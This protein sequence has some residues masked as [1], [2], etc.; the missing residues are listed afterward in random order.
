MSRK[1]SSI[2]HQLHS[3]MI[4]CLLIYLRNQLYQ[5]LTPP[6]ARNSHIINDCLL[7]LSDTNVAVRNSATVKDLKHAVENKVNE[8]EQSKMGHRHIFCM[9]RNFCL[10]YHNEKLLNDAAVLQSCHTTISKTTTHN[11]FSAGNPRMNQIQAI[12]QGLRPHSSVVMGKNTFM[13]HSLE[14]HAPSAGKPAFVG[15]IYDIVRNVGMIFT[16]CDPEEVSE[17]VAEYKLQP[18]VCSSMD[19]GMCS[20][21]QRLLGFHL[22]LLTGVFVDGYC[23]I[24]FLS[25]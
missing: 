24:E 10:S 22:N 13:R 17:M 7:L 9:C 21:W 19:I 20:L 14:I 12:R 6:S 4:L 23:P 18:L 8:M 25:V 5:M 15:A 2:Q 16:A 3:L 11:S 1:Q